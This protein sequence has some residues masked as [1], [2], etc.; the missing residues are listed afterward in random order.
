MTTMIIIIT[1]MEI[2]SMFTIMTIIIT[3]TIITTIVAIIKKTTIIIIIMTGI[4]TKIITI[5]FFFSYPHK[6]L[7]DKSSYNSSFLHHAEHCNTPANA[8]IRVLCKTF[9]REMAV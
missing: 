6:H 4:I 2:I 5:T 9:E 7:Y 8:C 1:M 3:L